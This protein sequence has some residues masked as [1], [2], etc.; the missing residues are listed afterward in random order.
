MN[1]SWTGTLTS[2]FRLN[3]WT[4]TNYFIDGQALEKFMDRH[5]IY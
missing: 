3:P 1:Y 5:W 2:R 4:G